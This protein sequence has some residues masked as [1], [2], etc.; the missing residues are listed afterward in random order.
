MSN[1][2]KVSHEIRTLFDTYGD[3]DYD[4]EPVSQTSHMIQ[5]AMLAMAHA[6]DDVDIIL[7]AFLHD[8]GHLLGHAEGAE[9]M[10]GFG[11]VGHEQIGADYLTARGF[12][13]K[14]CAMVRHHVDA[15]RYLVATDQEY[16][17]KLSP[18]STETLRWQGGPMTEMEAAGF[19]ANPYFEDIIRVRKWDE[20]AKDCSAKLAPLT[21]FEKLM[22][23]HLTRPIY[24]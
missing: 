9:S 18:A 5:C 15:K 19:R 16:A 14:V 17:A 8:I 7:G 10:G 4:G 23:D 3:N 6:P 11:T 20:K 24:L 2:K 21:T 13:P 1:G 12:S 22:E